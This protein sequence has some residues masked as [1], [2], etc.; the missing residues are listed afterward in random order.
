MD[1]V[2][3]FLRKKDITFSLKRYGVDAFAAMAQGL[4]CSL[5]I[6]T[7][8]N[9]VGTQAGMPFLNTIGDFAIKVSGP[10]ISIGHALSPLCCS[11][12]QPLDFQQMTLVAGG[13]LAVYVIAILAAEMASWFQRR[14]KDIL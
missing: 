4:F 1:K 13:P 5:L 8:I 14:P 11:P 12:W 7:I 2:R 9:T 3:E 10:A 6:G